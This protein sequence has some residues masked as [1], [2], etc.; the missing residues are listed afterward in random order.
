MNICSAFF[1]QKSIRLNEREVIFIKPDD[2]QDLLPFK[3]HIKFDSELK[4]V[5]NKNEF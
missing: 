5:L 3:K 1:Q 2:F 4:R